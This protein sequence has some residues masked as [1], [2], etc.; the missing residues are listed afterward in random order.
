MGTDKRTL[1]RELRALLEEAATEARR[2]G[3]GQV[4]M[5]HVAEAI[6]TKHSAVAEKTLGNGLGESITSMLS[7]LPRT[8]TPPELDAGTV[9]LIASC[10]G[11]PDAVT[12]VAERI[13]DQL[14][15]EPA[16]SLEPE[17]DAVGPRGPEQE[18]VA[19]REPF[20]SGLLTPETQHD[21]VGTPATEQ[22]RPE[23]TTERGAF[24]LPGQLARMADV[25][26]AEQPVV[27][28]SDVA[29][30][31]AALLTAKLPQTPLVVAGPGEGR[32]SLAECLAHL[33][34]SSDDVQR[35]AKMPVVRTKA[36]ALLAFGPAESLH[37]IADSCRGSAVLF[38]D[39]L[40][41]LASLGWNGMVDM[42]PL[43]VLRGLLGDPELPVVATVSAD[44]VDRLRARDVELFDQ[45]SRVELPPLAADEVRTIVDQRAT[46]L[47][48]FHEVTVPVDV[49]SAAL[50]PARESDALLQ[51]GLAVQR[52]DRAAAAAA[53]SGHE[54]VKPQDLGSTVSGQQY[55]AFDAEAARARLAA[56]IRGQDQAL[57]E[58]TELL[59]VSRASLDANPKR[60]DAVFLFAG[61]TGTGKTA[62]AL[63]LATELFGTDEALI[64]LDMS[65]YHDEWAISKLIGPP[66]GYVGSQEPESWLTTKIRKRPQSVLLLD[67]IEKADPRVWNTF[68]QVFDAGRLTDSAGRLAD[69]A[70][71]VIIMTT[72][73]GAEV[74]DDD[75]DLG[76]V[77]QANSAAAD[78]GAVQRMLKERM[79]PELLNRLDGTLV[80][81]PLTPETVRMIAQ[82]RLSDAI[83]RYHQRGWDI[84]CGDDVIEL[85]TARGYD[86]AY[87]ARPMLRAIDSLVGRSVARLERGSYTARVVD[88]VVVFDAVGPG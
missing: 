22:G 63:A 50:A 58:V 2:R 56:R 24:T 65:E 54:R 72:N 75:G 33:L 45:F 16:A 36:A 83:G 49:A 52:L 28:R 81:Q 25:V 59:A 78:V 69:F 37:A 20:A 79:R 77:A 55:I 23:V 53:I 13:R 40:E 61:P 70:D 35:L 31:L 51:P 9:A 30:R 15:S 5:C 73:I 6:R 17:S 64:R 48:A 7:A 41:A 39:D 80:F 18:D 57:A 26:S 47:A 44:Y 34:A 1:P 84:T 12:A 87:G 27:P 4:N 76:F 42:G 71:V 62:L 29:R 8:D 32:S 11:S 38:V 67:E 3:H 19:P 88:G 60:P 14:S 85:L 46:E 86:R 66:P 82:D 43:R 10:V 68:L 21:R 74:F